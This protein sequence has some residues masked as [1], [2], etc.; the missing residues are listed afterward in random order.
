MTETELRLGNLLEVDGNI[1]TVD[2]ISKDELYFTENQEYN[3]A[4]NAKPIPLNEQW[5]LDFGAK[6]FK[7]YWSY[8]RFR[9]SWKENYN[10]WY[11]LDLQ[12]LTYLTKIEFVHEWQNFNHV[13]NGKELEIKKA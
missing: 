2:S 12:S 9:L 8:S 5:L 11:V 3:H 4:L 1:W 7:D 6:Q 13:M 10:Y